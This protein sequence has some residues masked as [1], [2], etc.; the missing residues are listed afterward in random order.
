M[1][2]K[3]VNRNI[4]PL[5]CVGGFP[6]YYLLTIVDAPDS[7]YKLILDKH[8]TGRFTFERILYNRILRGQS[9]SFYGP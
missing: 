4:Y 7:H 2:L 9:R 6:G 5:H 1:K 8:Q 3:N